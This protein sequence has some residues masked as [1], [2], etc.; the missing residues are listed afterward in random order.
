MQT[1]S[2][3]NKP[4][5]RF[6]VGAALALALSAGPAAAQL[7]TTIPFGGPDKSKPATPAPA[8]PA[9][10]GISAQL[11]SR[12]YHRLPGQRYLIARDKPFLFNAPAGRHVVAAVPGRG[13]SRPSLT[14]TERAT[15]KAHQGKR[16]GSG[17]TVFLDNRDDSD[18]IV[19]LAD[20]APLC[21]ITLL[22]FQR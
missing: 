16:L 6:L 9:V 17:L 21:W 4:V 14:V 8:D 10:A 18:V 20:P 15:G 2:A 5:G 7:K 13:C 11:E 19:A 1:A 12:G 22:G 3:R